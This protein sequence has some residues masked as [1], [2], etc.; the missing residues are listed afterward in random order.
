MPKTLCIMTL[1]EKLE[2]ELVSGHFFGRNSLR[3]SRIVMRCVAPPYYKRP[4]DATMHEVHYIYDLIEITNN[5]M[6][7]ITTVS[8]ISC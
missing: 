4:G 1:P 2:S 3:A 6:R 7:T 5:E 8:K